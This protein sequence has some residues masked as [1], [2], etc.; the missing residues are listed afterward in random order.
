MKEYN[1]LEIKKRIIDA[2]YKAINELIKIA[3][4]PIIITDKEKKESPDLAAD[5]LKNAAASKKLA[6]MDSLE[7]LSKIEGEKNII[8]SEEKYGATTK[9][10]GFAENRAK[11]K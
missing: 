8:E 5:K 3:E 10:V 7:I 11:N 1:P 6:I 2:G 9:D 4:E